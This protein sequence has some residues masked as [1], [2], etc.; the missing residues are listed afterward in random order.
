M[1]WI[2]ASCMLLAAPA[3]WISANAFTDPCRVEGTSL[4]VEQADRLAIVD[5]ATLAVQDT[6]L[7]PEFVRRAAAM[8][9]VLDEVSW[10]RWQVVRTADERV[11]RITVFDS[12]DGSLVFDLSFS[13]RMELAASAVSPSHRFVIHVQANNVAS[14]ATI[15]D[16]QSGDSS[17]AT[18][19]HHSDIAAYAIG[20]VFSPDELC[21]AISMERADADGADT[22]FVDLESGAVIRLRIPDIQVLDW[23]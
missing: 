20:I 8:R 22:W 6:P 13:R 4:L 14:E 11:H 5:P 3:T 10:R 2:V 19:S 9:A 12:G 23:I 15:L 18:I 1:R 21:A 17:F 16:A 7:D